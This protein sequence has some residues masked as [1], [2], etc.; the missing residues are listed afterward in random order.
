[1][2]VVFWIRRNPAIQVKVLKSFLLGNQHGLAGLGRIEPVSQFFIEH[3]AEL[4]LG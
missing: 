3:F 2:S 1:M 4:I